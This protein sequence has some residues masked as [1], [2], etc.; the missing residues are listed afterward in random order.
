MRITLCGG[1]WKTHPSMF[2]QY[3]KEVTEI[4]PA[5]VVRKPLFEHV[6]AGPARFLI[7]SGMPRKEAIRLM[8][9][10]FAEYRIDIGNE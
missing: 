9:T 8:Q 6:C 10:Q 5:A 2:E 4:Y 7:E 3:R 1:A